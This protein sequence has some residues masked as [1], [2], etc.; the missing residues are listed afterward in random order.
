MVNM[1]LTRLYNLIDSKYY[2]KYFQKL[3]LFSFLKDISANPSSKIF[4]IYF[5]CHNKEKKRR[6]L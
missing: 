2:L 3:L 6:V 4:V 1:V 5:P